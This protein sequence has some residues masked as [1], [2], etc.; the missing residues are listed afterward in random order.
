LYHPFSA[1][2][3]APLAFNSSHITHHRVGFNDSGQIAT[4][5]VARK[6]EGSSFAQKFIMQVEER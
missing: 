5:Q 2:L 6:S 3:L 4:E 1:V